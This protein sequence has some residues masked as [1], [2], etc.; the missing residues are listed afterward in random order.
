MPT[1]D[2]VY[3]TFSLATYS[4]FEFLKPLLIFVF[5]IIFII[6][7]IPEQDDKPDMVLIT[8][9]RIVKIWNNSKE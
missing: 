8:K 5:T 7:Q 9:S 2:L 1:C 6:F 3:S 4:L